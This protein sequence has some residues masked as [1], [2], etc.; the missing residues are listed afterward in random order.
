VAAAVAVWMFPLQSPAQALPDAPGVRV[1]AGGKLLHSTP[2]RF[3]ADAPNGTVVLEATLNAQGEVADARVLSGP[4]ELRK[5]ALESVLE[6]HYSAEVAP[7]PTVRIAIQLERV[8]SAT[9]SPATPRLPTVKGS[10]PAS[11]AQWTGTIADIRYPGLSADLAQQIESRMPVR[12]G[13][14]Y[15]HETFGSVVS[16]M[17][18]VDRHLKLTVQIDRDG[19]PVIL[20]VELASAQAA[21]APEAITPQRVRVGGNIQSRMLMTKVPPVYPPD[22]KQARVQGKVSL[23]VLIAP[24]GSVANVQ[25]VKGDALLAPSAMDAVRQW[26]YRPTLVNGQPV[27]VLTMVDVNYTLLP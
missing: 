17:S 13:D 22:A 19:G 27:E 1:D 24:D 6:W 4:D 15:T 8:S 26:V 9:S 10:L 16:A 21:A 23:G 14:P 5:G 18:A 11:A 3:P 20:V 25:L 12:K 7:P 2:V